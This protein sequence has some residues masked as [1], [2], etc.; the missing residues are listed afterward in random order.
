MRKRGNIAATARTH[1]VE[2]NQIRNWRS[3]REKLIEKRRQILGLGQ[4]TPEIVH[5][6]L[7]W[8]VNYM[9]D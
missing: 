9:Y 4:C 8:K 5:I 2:P 1:S 6:T 3:V 7:N